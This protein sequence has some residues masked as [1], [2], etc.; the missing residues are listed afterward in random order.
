M[1]TFLINM[2][3]LPDHFSYSLN[4]LSTYLS[5][6]NVCRLP[7]FISLGFT[8]EDVIFKPS[9]ET[10]AEL[11]CEEVLIEIQLKKEPLLVKCQ[12][13]QKYRHFD[14]DASKNTPENSRIVLMG[15]INNLQANDEN[16]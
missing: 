15:D 8:H 3:K 12:S 11:I 16:T 4:Q 9:R 6:L 10:E 2:L 13:R 14:W 7:K 5:I 1:N